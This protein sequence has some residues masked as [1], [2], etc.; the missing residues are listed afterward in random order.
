LLTINAYIYLTNK[1]D[2]ELYGNIRIT[3]QNLCEKISK[4]Y[5]FSANRKLLEQMCG[6]AYQTAHTVN[7]DGQ[8]VF[9]VRMYISVCIFNKAWFSWVLFCLH[10]IYH[11]LNYA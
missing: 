11:I 5:Q 3:D 1:N 9:E 2:F 4:V 10:S 8:Q 7:Q 6:D